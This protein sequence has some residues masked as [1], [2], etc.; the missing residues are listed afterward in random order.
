MR[1]HRP[2][3]VDHSGTTKSDDD[4]T[5]LEFAHSRRMDWPSRRK[6]CHGQSIC[7]GWVIRPLWENGPLDT[8]NRQVSPSATWKL[9]PF[10]QSSVPHDPRTHRNRDDQPRCPLCY[11][12]R[13][14]HRCGSPTHVYRLPC[15][16]MYPR[17]SSAM[18]SSPAVLGSGTRSPVIVTLSN[19]RSS[20]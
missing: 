4:D 20:S 7:H 5:R 6:H 18:P 11:Q 16:R 12:L 13:R 2:I 10:R 8:F 3:R 1:W 15:R 17:P 9:W 14:L 19:A